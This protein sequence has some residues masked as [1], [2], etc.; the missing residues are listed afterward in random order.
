MLLPAAVDGVE[1]GGAMGTLR[2]PTEG[3]GTGTRA[4]LTPPEEEEDEEEEEDAGGVVMGENEES[5][6][7]ENA[8]SSAV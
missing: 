4:R 1:E 2:G 7:L 8:M 3:R 5:A 6:A